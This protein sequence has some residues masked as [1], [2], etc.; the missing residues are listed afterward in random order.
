MAGTSIT[1]LSKLVGHKRLS[2]TEKYLELI[3][4]KQTESTKLDE[5]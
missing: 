1:T 5:L 3:K 2:T 4:E